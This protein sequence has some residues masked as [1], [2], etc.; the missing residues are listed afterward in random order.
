MARDALPIY[1]VDQGKTNKAKKEREASSSKMGNSS[2][3]SSNFGSLNT[4][5][6]QAGEDKIS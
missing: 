2:N 1:K 4:D 6:Y 3:N 5:P